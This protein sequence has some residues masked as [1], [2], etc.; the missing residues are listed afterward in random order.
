MCG[1]F[2]YV[3]DRPAWPLIVSGLKRL[4]YRGY[5]SWGVTLAHDGTLKTRK[6]TGHLDRL[7]SLAPLPGTVGMGHTRWA[8]H[9]GVTR[10]NAHPL[11]DCRGEIAVIHNGIIENFRELR[12]ELRKKGHRFVS[13]TDTE[14]VPHLLEEVRKGSLEDRIRHV[15]KRLKGSYALVALSAGEPDKLVAV[16]RTSP[17]ILGFGKGENFVASGIPAMLDHTRRVVALDNDQWAVIRKEGIE[18]YGFDGRPVRPK[19]ERVTWSLKDAELGGFDHFMLKEIYDTPRAIHDVLVGRIDDVG[20][21]FDVE[22]SITARELHDLKRLTLL[23]CGTSYHACLLG[24]RILEQ[25]AKIPVTVELASEYRNTV[26]L[27]ESEMLVIAVTQSGETADTLASLQLAR[28]EGHR[29]LAITNVNG[30]SITRAAHGLFLLHAGPEISVAATKSFINQ[31]VAFYLLGLHLAARRG[32]L[33]PSEVQR[34][35]QEIKRLPR[36]VQ[37]VLDTPQPIQRH[38]RTLARHEDV[39]YIGRGL[40]YPTAL[41]GALKL[42]EISYIHAEGLAAGEM[43][44]GPLALISRGVP[45]VALT[46]QDET[47]TVMTGN[48][49]EVQARGA[50][51]FAVAQQGDTDMPQL[52]QQVLRVPAGDP[53]TYPVPATVALQLLAYYT[54]RARGCEIDKPRNLAKS[55]TVE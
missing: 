47:Y 19:V 25:L 4:E 33:D 29:T 36:L 39:Y 40:N 8:T 52:A 46:P 21:S 41:E 10:T 54:A 15:I 49:A 11:L 37:D 12:Q 53:L 17:V 42:K 7:L 44:H 22:G 13:E 27:P 28:K 43:K 24:R 5:D 30:S 55:V 6:D 9:G 1:I 32:T 2:G 50:V 31:A 48:L 16:R 14:V 35:G 51:G 3:G 34:L 38:A 45:V 20:R 26:R 18:L 23:A